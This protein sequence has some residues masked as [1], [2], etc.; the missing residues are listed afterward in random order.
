MF[1][2]LKISDDESKRLSS[3]LKL[4]FTF[5][6]KKEVLL[7]LEE[8]CLRDEVSLNQLFDLLK[9]EVIAFQKDK[10]LAVKQIRDNLFAKRYPLFW[11]KEQKFISFINNLKIDSNLIKI[12]HSKSFEENKLNLKLY[13][14]NLADLKK[15]IKKLKE[16]NF[17]IAD[18]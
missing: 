15:I 5:S 6:E 8:I 18:L 12:S 4:P 9:I 13:W 14:S 10:F 1:N 16:I 17:S 11:Q 7:N 2:I 3:L